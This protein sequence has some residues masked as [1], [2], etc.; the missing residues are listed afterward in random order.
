MVCSDQFRR[1]ADTDSIRF[2]LFTLQSAIRCFEQNP[3]YQAQLG[4]GSV[5]LCMSKM[6]FRPSSALALN[7]ITVHSVQTILVNIV[8]PYILNIVEDVSLR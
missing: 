7:V 6:G 8:V 4:P 2:E 1:S 5:C 3:P